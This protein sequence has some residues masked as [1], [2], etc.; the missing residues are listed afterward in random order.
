[1]VKNQSFMCLFLLMSFSVEGAVEIGSHSTF[2]MNFSLRTS[3]GVSEGGETEVTFQAP[4]AVAKYR[5]GNEADD[6]VK[7]GF[8]YRRYFEQNRAEQT[9]HVKAYIML[10]SN[11][12]QGNDQ[13]TQLSDV[14][15]SYISFNNFLGKGVNVWVGRRWYDRQSIFINDHFWLNTGQN[16]RAGAG[17][18][19]IRVG[20]ADLNVALIMSEDHAAK[21]LDQN[22]APKESVNS[23]ALDL[24][25]KNI[26]INPGGKLNLWAY[27]NLRPENDEARLEKEQGYGL[28]V[29]HQQSILE[30]KGR[31]IV[32]L[33][34]REG[35][36]V[37][38]SDFNPNPKLNDGF[39][40]D[41]NYLQFATD[42]RASLSNDWSLSFV[43]LY[44]NTEEITSSGLSET[45][46]YGLGVRPHYRINDLWSFIF[47]LGH[48]QV[49][50]GMS[51]AGLTKYSIAL[52]LN[53]IPGYGTTPVIRTYVTGASWDDEFQGQVGGEKYSDETAGWTVGVQAEWNWGGYHE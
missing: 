47:D 4:G 39:T 37:G 5:L 25:L 3:V 43:A 13:D 51:N 42:L 15:Q 32:H 34:Y 21:S 48:D 52:K 30:G 7:L 41:A 10:E 18:E 6:N 40:L 11:D 9:N 2:N 24:R 8:E 53:V 31:N 12:R 23:T 38:R 16:S 44:R 46:V 26:V 29:W 49:D 27:Y 22:I 17:I 50:N 45:K 1:M 33:T 28:G 14:A 35:S 20:H 36:A 19:G